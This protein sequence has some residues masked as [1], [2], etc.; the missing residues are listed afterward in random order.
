MAMCPLIRPLQ[1]LDTSTGIA[2]TATG[3][4]VHGAAVQQA[5]LALIGGYVTLQFT[6]LWALYYTLLFGR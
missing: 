5:V 6:A 4:D 3:T 2:R 1:T